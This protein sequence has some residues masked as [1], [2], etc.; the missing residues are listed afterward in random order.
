MTPEG[1]QM[2]ALIVWDVAQIAQSESIW[3][4]EV[5]TVCALLGAILAL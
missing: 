5:A 1:T 3:G 2:T 4:P